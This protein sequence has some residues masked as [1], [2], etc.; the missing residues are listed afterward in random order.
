MT[1]QLPLDAYWEH[2]RKLAIMCRIVASWGYIGA[3]G[4]LS[5][6][7]PDEDI[8]LITP[9]AGSEKTLVRADQIFVYD[10]DGKLIHHPGGDLIISEPAEHPIHTRIHRDRPE[11]L[12]VA[13]LHSPHSMLLGVVDEPIV[14]VFNQAFRFYKGVPTFDDPRLVMTDEH[15]GELSDTLG[16]KL[17]CQ[18]RGHGNVIVGETPEVGLMNVYFLEE[19]AK[20]QI[21]S[22][23][24]GGA[25]PFPLEIIEEAYKIQRNMKTPI[26]QLVWNY[27][28]RRVMMA[29]VPV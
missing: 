22:N 13:H 23:K 18:M 16:D 24:L 25:K 26:A 7:V 12:S 20:F 15:A 9:G 10:L 17:A 6:R 5:I 1:E 28:E 19:N 8:V 29:G 3:F 21:E 27:F 2:R 11:M 4:H 14:P